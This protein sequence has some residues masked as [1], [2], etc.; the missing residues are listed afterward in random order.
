MEEAPST[1][2][3]VA[4]RGRG[5]QDRLC[6]QRRGPAG[7]P[8]RGLPEGRQHRLSHGRGREGAAE[9]RCPSAERRG[10]SA[11]SHHSHLSAPA[12][13]TGGGLDA[14]ERP[15]RSEGNPFPAHSPDP[16]HRHAGAPALR[17]RGGRSG[18]GKPIPLALTRPLPY[19]PPSPPSCV[20]AA[21][22]HQPELSLERGGCHLHI[23]VRGW[24]LPQPHSWKSTERRLAAQSEPALPVTRRLK[25]RG[26]AAADL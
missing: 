9:G 4:S 2:L 20:V 26:S 15:G 16:S 25:G 1:V 7:R 5:Q 19:T 22:L 18:I 13:S 12:V 14:T 6:Q 17:G 24:H 21:A 23:R 3:H 8:E 10:R 11:F